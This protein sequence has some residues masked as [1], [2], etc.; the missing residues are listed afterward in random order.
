[1]KSGKKL[2]FSFKTYNIICRG[3]RTWSSHRGQFGVSLT[4]TQKKNWLAVERNSQTLLQ[5]HFNH[6]RFSLSLLHCTF[7]FCSFFLRAEHLC[8]SF[9]WETT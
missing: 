9:V 4:H 3:S 1:M 6:I 2:F 8:R 7:Q 5:Q